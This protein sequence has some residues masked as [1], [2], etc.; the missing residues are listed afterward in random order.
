MSSEEFQRHL[1]PI[2]G[3]IQ[4]LENMEVEI[5][6]LEHKAAEAAEILLSQQK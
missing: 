5:D 3:A 1:K 2:N 4:E 6:L